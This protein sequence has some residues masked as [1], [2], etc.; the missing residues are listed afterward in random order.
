MNPVIEA[1]R[2]NMLIPPNRILKGVYDDARRGKHLPGTKH[3]ARRMLC[4][5]SCLAHA[6]AKDDKST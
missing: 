4:G 5:T 1:I 3:N 2:R 6:L